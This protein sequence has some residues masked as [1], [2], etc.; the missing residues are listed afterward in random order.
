MG[1]CYKSKLI[2]L[3][4]S[5]GYSFHVEGE[6]LNFRIEKLNSSEKSYQLTLLSISETGRFEDNGIRMSMHVRTE[7]V[8][9]HLC[10]PKKQCPMYKQS[11]VI[12]QFIICRKFY[13]ENWKVKLKSVVEEKN[14]FKNPDETF[15]K[16]FLFFITTIPRKKRDRKSLEPCQ[17]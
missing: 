14:E 17:S 9:W 13:I 5:Q 2:S 12:E 15:W 1:S 3:F 8:F 10:F 16:Q 6:N 11:F 4:A 7:N